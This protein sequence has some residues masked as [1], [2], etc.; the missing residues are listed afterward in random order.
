MRNCFESAAG[1][2]TALEVESLAPG[3]RP[4]FG[5]APVGDFNIAPL[6]RALL[7]ADLLERLPSGEVVLD[8]S[9]VNT[10]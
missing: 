5:K 7:E 3:S 10:T 8:L 4:V 2:L 1:A 6:G 9:E